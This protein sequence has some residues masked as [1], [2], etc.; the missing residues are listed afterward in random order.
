MFATFW[1]ETCPHSCLYLDKDEKLGEEVGGGKGNK[2]R[3]QATSS[4]RLMSQGGQ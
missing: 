4:W 3:L 1:R 2:L